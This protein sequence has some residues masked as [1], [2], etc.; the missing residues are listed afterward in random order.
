MWFALGISLGIHALL[1]TLHFQFPERSQAFR[2]KAMD[3]I[4]V[5]AKSARNPA[6]AQ[7]LAQSSLDGGG[8]TGAAFGANACNGEP[9]SES[10]SE[11]IP[12]IAAQE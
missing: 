9:P 10:S 3:I 11:Y 7:A 1:L 8:N 4:L 2:E 6:D 12:R 5:N